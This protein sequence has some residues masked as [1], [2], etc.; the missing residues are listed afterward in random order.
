[1][2]VSFSRAI[3]QSKGILEAPNNFI[4]KDRPKRACLRTA[5]SKLAVGGLQRRFD[6]LAKAGTL[7]LNITY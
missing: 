6:A 4:L 3:T 7:R 2:V 1:M 5:L